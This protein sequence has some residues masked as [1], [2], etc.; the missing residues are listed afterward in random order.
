M[1]VE[2]ARKVAGGESKKSERGE[3]EGVCVFRWG[4]GGFSGRNVRERENE[5]QGGIQRDKR[6]GERQRG[7]ESAH[8]HAR[9]RER[10]REEERERVR[11]RA[12][13]RESE[14]AREREIGCM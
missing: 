14:R 11:E 10:W 8:M 4:W 1:A 12:R 6:A 2:R 3:D 5:K 9:A 13:E 7:K